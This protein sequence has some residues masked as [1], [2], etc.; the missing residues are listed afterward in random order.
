MQQ[1]YD[2]I[3]LTNISHV[4]VAM[5]GSPYVLTH[6]L[7][8]GRSVTLVGL[9]HELGQPDL[10]PV[11]DANGTLLD[12]RRA[13]RVGN[14]TSVSL[15]GLAITGGYVD[16]RA[17]GPCTSCGAGVY[18]LGKLTVSHCHVYSNHASGNSSEPGSAV[19]HPQFA[20]GGLSSEGGATLTLRNSSVHANTATNGGGV[21]ANNGGELHIRQSEVYDNTGNVDGGGILVGLHATMEVTNTNISNNVA[22][23][24]GGGV[25][26][27][28]DAMVHLDGIVMDGNRAFNGGGLCTHNCGNSSH[29]AFMHTAAQIS[30]HH[31]TARSNN[32]TARGGSFLCG[33]SCRLDLSAA[34]VADSS[35][36]EGG[37]LFVEGR[38]NISNSS[39]TNNQARLGGAI[40]GVDHDGAVS[41]RLYDTNLTRNNASKGSAIFWAGAYLEV[42]RGSIAN[43]IASATQIMDRSK[44]IRDSGALYNTG[45]GYLYGALIA[46][47]HGR[48]GTGINVY[49]G[50]TLTYVFPAP[51]GYYL[52]G[53]FLCR[54]IECT[55]VDGVTRVPCAEQTCKYTLLNGR[56]VSNLVQGPSD[57][58]IP[59]PCRAGVY[60]NSTETQHQSSSFC[61]G[62][63]L[64]GYF[65]PNTSTITPV[66]APPGYYTNAGATEPKAC[67]I[68]THTDFASGLATSRFACKRCPQFS[69]TVHIAQHGISACVCQPM[70]YRNASAG[71]NHSQCLPCPEHCDCPRINTT[72]DR[73]RVSP[74]YW[75]PSQTSLDVRRC[76][77]ARTC[78]GDVP[79]NT[80][81]QHG[82]KYN[83]TSR[84]LCD[85]SLGVEGVYCLLCT[86]ADSYFDDVAEECR[87][88]GASLLHTVI[89]V[90][91]IAGLAILL[92]LIDH[93]L[94]SYTV[95]GVS[96]AALLWSRICVAS[97]QASL[98]QK[99][100]LAISFYQIVSHLAPVYKIQ[101]PASYRSFLRYVSVSSLSFTWFP[102]FHLSCF[103]IEGL[104]A[105]L[106]FALFAPLVVAGMIIC[107]H[108]LVALK[109]Q[110]QVRRSSRRRLSLAGALVEAKLTEDNH[111]LVSA[112]PLLSALPSALVIL[113]LTFPS[114][115][116]LGFRALAKCECFNLDASNKSDLDRVCFSPVDFSY[117]CDSS[118]YV[119]ENEK[120]VGVLLVIVHAVAIPL[121][122]CV[123]LTVS[124]SAIING[125]PT[126]LSSALSWLHQEY[127]PAWYLWELGIATQKLM[128]I[129]GLSLF[130][131]DASLLSWQLDAAIFLSLIFLSA[132]A[133]C[134]PFI[135]RDLNVIA[136]FSQAALV[137]VLVLST[138]LERSG[139]G[140]RSTA[141]GSTALAEEQE[142]IVITVILFSS[143]VL[144]ILVAIFARHLLFIELPE[145]SWSNGAPVRVRILPSDRWH[146]FIS[147]VWYARTHA[148]AYAYVVLS[149]SP[150]RG[151]ALRECHPTM[152]IHEKKH[153]ALSAAQIPSLALC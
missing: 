53:V 20:G 35:A 12:P 41:L 137:F 115:A 69:T 1:L 43:N 106:L 132:Q 125:R 46:G 124:R 87:G 19:W 44:A 23:A 13:I 84:V 135:S 4:L 62:Q 107:Y 150:D 25:F 151:H 34:I 63:C 29:C 97:R 123:L 45:H 88:C 126:L 36:F 80:G 10:R 73:L 79:T 91:S 143:S 8:I 39:F 144:V 90:F 113:F 57:E 14:G 139:G 104:R 7:E 116:S 138:K 5:A 122:F 65:C 142:K 28:E 117:Q 31:L 37:A 119:K 2:A 94:R 93:L 42:H 78:A 76:R 24:N 81:L 71:K 70:Y 55:G 112:S 82:A 146:C 26:I 86:E 48:H 141:L 59:T 145:V 18:N 89:L 118:G 16:G 147:H 133:I 68:G 95:N 105:R 6:S 56:N 17:L 38:A 129:G 61:A 3:A 99:C 136:T 92:K 108:L 33:S 47:N 22:K 60:A 149:L 27:Y 9:P 52:S 51:L 85:R 40:A 77:Y 32:A 110:L 11:I 120:N 64:A 58:S 15:V 134:L 131:D 111:A 98:L 66:S 101:Y 114:G 67:E 121:L 50:G 128:L 30:I 148:H 140:D 49:N 130:I 152:A 21:H 127:R 75:R 102:G 54:K 153:A 72:V 103:R 96:V 74:G 109:G 83:A 100:K